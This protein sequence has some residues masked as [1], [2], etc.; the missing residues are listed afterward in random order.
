MLALMHPDCTV[1]D[2]FQ[3]DLVTRHDMEVYVDKDYKQSAARGK[4]TFRQFN[5]VT[6]TWDDAAI[7]R[8]NTRARIRPAQSQQGQ[9]PDDGGAAK[10]PRQ[11]VA[12][13]AC[14]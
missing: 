3:P 1:W 8:F 10:V 5:F 9:R 11:A 6:D 13:G 14:P 2:V 7:C 4:L 12:S